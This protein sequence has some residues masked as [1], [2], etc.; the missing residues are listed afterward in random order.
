M[1]FYL[2]LFLASWNASVDLQAQDRAFRLGQKKDCR[3]Y[4][5]VS[6]GTIEEAQYQRQLYKQQMQNISLEGKQ[7]RRLF[8]GVQGVQGQE[9]EL[10]G[11][12]NLLKQSNSTANIVK[13]NESMEETWAKAK[14]E[15]NATTSNSGCDVSDPNELIFTTHC[16][17]SFSLW[18]K[19]L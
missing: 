16:K 4:R 17:F 1:L 12:A 3:I 18:Q 9:G 11:I 14:A 13:R 7:E 6:S 2:V 15:L 8:K 19:F 10:F 5:F